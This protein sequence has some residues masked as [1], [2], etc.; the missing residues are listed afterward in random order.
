MDK[1]LSL[2]LINLEMSNNE[3]FICDTLNVNTCEIK[4]YIILPLNFVNRDF[5]AITRYKDFYGRGQIALVKYIQKAHK[6]TR[7]GASDNDKGKM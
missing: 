3:K 6:S 1:K 5:Q 2:S 4:I 7:L